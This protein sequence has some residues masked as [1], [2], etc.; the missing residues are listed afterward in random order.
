MDFDQTVIQSISIIILLILLGM[1][2][3]K[4]GVLIEEDGGLFARLITQYT[5]PALIFHALSTLSG[6]GSIL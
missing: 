5:L 4:M 1:W 6:A 3:R 2:F